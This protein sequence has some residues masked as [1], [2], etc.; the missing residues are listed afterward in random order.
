MLS[1]QAIGLVVFLV[2]LL[3]SVVGHFT[4]FR[5]TGRLD[6]ARHAQRDLREDAPGFG[7]RP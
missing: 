3:I 2:L 4:A 5:E 6:G 1:E 7:V